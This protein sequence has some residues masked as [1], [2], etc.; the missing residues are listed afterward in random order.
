MYRYELAEH[1]RAGDGFLMHNNLI[2]VRNENG[3]ESIS[4]KCKQTRACVF[5]FS[6]VS[7]KLNGM[8][9]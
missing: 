3:F 6:V 4:E 8:L 5:E 2:F 7:S 9:H 1:Q